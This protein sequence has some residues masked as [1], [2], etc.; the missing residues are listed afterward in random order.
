MAAPVLRSSC[1]CFQ[2]G[3]V[4][5][6]SFLPDGQ[7]NGGDLARQGQLRHLRLDAGT[8]PLLVK[9]LQWSRENAGTHGRAFE[10]VL[11]VVVVVQVQS[12]D[13]YLFTGTLQLS[14]DLLIIGAAA[15]LQT[16][17]AVGPELT[18]R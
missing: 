17:T 16:Q 7:G 10:D 2:F 6:I 3:S 5:A 4:E 11:Q 18:F 1:L 15:R 12:P 8:Q 9:L 14:F 13:Q